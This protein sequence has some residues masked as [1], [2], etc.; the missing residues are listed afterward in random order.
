MYHMLTEMIQIPRAEYDRLRKERTQREA[1][2]AHYSVRYEAAAAEMRRIHNQAHE[3]LRVTVDDMKKLQ[4]RVK[5]LEANQK[6]E[7]NDA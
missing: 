1:A 2:E 3:Q 4:A 6:E 5:E 7:E